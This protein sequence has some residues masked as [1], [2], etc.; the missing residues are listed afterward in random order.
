MQV[1][2]SP[3]GCYVQY[4]FSSQ[5]QDVFDEVSKAVHDAVH[6][7]VDRHKMTQGEEE[8]YPL[9]ARVTALEEK[10][11]SLESIL[12]I[13]TCFVVASG[14]IW[15]AYQNWELIQKKASDAWN[16]MPAMNEWLPQW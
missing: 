16:Q 13:S 4:R 5:D 6:R 8:E 7:A 15:V 14:L 3:N 11:S 9:R 1:I 12:K 2:F 10:Q